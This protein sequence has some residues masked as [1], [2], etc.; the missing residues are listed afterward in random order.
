MHLDATP[1]VVM[2]MLV[3]GVKT[4]LLDVAPATVVG[5]IVSKALNTILDAA[6]ATRPTRQVAVSDSELFAAIAT[7]FI[8]STVDHD[9]R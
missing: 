3:C 8:P 6:S 1:A 5:M 2:V 4:P 9:D 7:H